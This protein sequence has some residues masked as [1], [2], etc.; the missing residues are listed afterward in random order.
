MQLYG[1]LIRSATYGVAFQSHSWN[2]WTCESAWLV[3]DREG[4][5]RFVWRVRESP[6]G[7]STNLLEV[8]EKYS[9]K[10]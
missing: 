10:R 8:V 3:I 9:E 4:V 1:G 7:P 5:I 2:G 6:K